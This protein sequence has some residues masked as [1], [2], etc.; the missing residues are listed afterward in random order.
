MRIKLIERNAPPGWNIRVFTE[1]DFWFLCAQQQIQVHE[2]PL[3]RLGMHLTRRDRHVIFVSDRLRGAEKQF[4]LWHEF[5]HG[6][7]HPAGI[8][9]FQGYDSLVEQ[10]ADAFAACA[11]IPR[12]VVQHCWPSEIADL[13]GY[14]EDLI[15]FRFDLFEMWKL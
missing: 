6:L 8:R 5:G 4:V 7:L 11:M 2:V 15:Q 12:T 9:F 10:E 13:Y 14:P 1:E 3:E